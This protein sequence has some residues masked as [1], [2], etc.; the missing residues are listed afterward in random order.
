MFSINLESSSFKGM[1]LKN[2]DFADVNP[3][4][5]VPAIRDGDLKLFEW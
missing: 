2:E 1:H 4:K 3:N 5:K